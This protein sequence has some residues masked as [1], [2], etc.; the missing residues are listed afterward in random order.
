[1]ENYS[2]LDT[3][4]KMNDST[5]NTLIVKYENMLV[6]LFFCPIL[7]IRNIDTIIRINAIVHTV[8]PIKG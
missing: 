6:M 2:I 8:A 1:M 5:E 7:F 3:I 4:R